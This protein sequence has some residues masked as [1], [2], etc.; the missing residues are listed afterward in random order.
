MLTCEICGKQVKTAQGL[1]G[2]K[3]FVHDITGSNTE[4]PVAPLATEQQVIELE[5]RLQQLEYATGLRELVRV[6]G[7]LPSEPATQGFGEPISQGIIIREQTIPERLTKGSWPNDMKNHAIFCSI[8]GIYVI[9]DFK[10][11][12]VAS[13]HLTRHNS[14][15]L[16]IFVSSTPPRARRS[17]LTLSA[18]SGVSSIFDSETA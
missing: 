18:E 15:A 7:T 13:E 16:F 14:W 6:R 5:D 8:V 11:M 4:K 3:N 2:H 1:R 9:S 17:A 12:V 10:P